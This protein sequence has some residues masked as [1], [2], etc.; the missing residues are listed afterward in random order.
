M[1]DVATD[2][3]IAHEVGSAPTSCDVC[4]GCR[5]PLPVRAKRQGEIAAHWECAA[6]RAPLTGILV[7]E[8]AAQMADAIRIGQIHFDTVDVPAIPESLRQ[9]VHDFAACRFEGSAP[10]RRSAGARMPA[11]FDVTILPLDEE[12]TPRAKPLV[13]LAIDLTAQ[14]LGMVTAA[15][16]ESQFIALQM[17]H[18]AGIVQLLSKVV[19]TNEIEIDFY[20]SGVQFLLRFGRSPGASSTLQSSPGER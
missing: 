3:I 16:I 14:G 2:D 20:N 4:P 9:L 13:G 15:P 11:E 6:C 5:C 17:R 19:W 12:W 7:K 1:N 18:P 8:Q 10:D